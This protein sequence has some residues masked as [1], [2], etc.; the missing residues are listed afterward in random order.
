MVIQAKGINQVL[1]IQLFTPNLTTFMVRRISLVNLTNTLRSKCTV[2]HDQN[3]NFI[4]ADR[5][6][7]HFVE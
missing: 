4:L 2:G 7:P 5:F 3:S 6:L 1:R